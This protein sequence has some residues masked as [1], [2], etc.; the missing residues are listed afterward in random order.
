ML[1]VAPLVIPTAMAQPDGRDH[2]NMNRPVP[3]PTPAAHDDI[4]TL[5][6]MVNDD[7][8]NSLRD[9]LPPPSDGQVL[10]PY[11]EPR[12]DSPEGG[13]ELGRD[14]EPITIRTDEDAVSGRDDAEEDGAP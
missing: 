6:Q 11:D 12:E 14:Q 10:E 8:S 4:P 5:T 13:L 2:P 3:S 7:T 1:P 9:N